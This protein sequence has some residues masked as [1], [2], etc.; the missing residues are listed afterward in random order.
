MASFVGRSVIFAI[1]SFAK[2][3]TEDATANSQYN[4]QDGHEDTYDYSQ[5]TVVMLK[6][7][8]QLLGIETAENGNRQT[9]E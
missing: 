2:S 5:E 4:G 9:E 3:P 8:P 6:D 7:L 1:K